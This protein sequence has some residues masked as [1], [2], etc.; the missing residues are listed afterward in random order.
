M[1]DVLDVL[2]SLIKLPEIWTLCVH[3]WYL[4]RKLQAQTIKY[5]SHYI[6]IVLEKVIQHIMLGIMLAMCV[7]RCQLGWH[8]A[9]SVINSNGWS[10][11]GY[12]ITSLSLSLSHDIN[13]PFNFHKYVFPPCLPSNTKALC[14]SQLWHDPQYLKNRKSNSSLIS[15]RSVWIV[16]TI[17][18][19][20]SYNNVTQLTKHENYNPKS[21]EKLDN[22]SSDKYYLLLEHWKESIS[23]RESMFL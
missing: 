2:L 13:T 15:V 20:A 5:S 18:A 3:Y 14:I 10:V 23:F 1:L 6:S 21:D 7:H 17:V 16:Q 4:I 22:V 19:L 9:F 8:L 11:E 12:F